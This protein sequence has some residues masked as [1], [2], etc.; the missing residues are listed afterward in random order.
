MTTILRERLDGGFMLEPV[1]D[2]LGG[3][4]SILLRL[5]ESQDLGVNNARIGIINST[6]TADEELRALARGKLEV[7]FTT[8]LDERV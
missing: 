4:R 6:M 7:E 3:I 2:V 8:K 5:E 1:A